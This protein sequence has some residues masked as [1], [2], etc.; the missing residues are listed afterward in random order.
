[1][2]TLHFRN[3]PKTV[4]K[5]LTYLLQCTLIFKFLCLYAKVHNVNTIPEIHLLCYN[6]CFFL[7]SYSA[8][9]F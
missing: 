3:N 1:M 2:F 4:N 6:Y 9:L 5:Q 8:T 7:I